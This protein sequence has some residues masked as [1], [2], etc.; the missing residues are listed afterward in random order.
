MSFKIKTLTA[1]II[2]LSLGSVLSAQELVLQAA[3]DFPVLTVEGFV[4][5][6]KKEKS[7]VLSVNAGK[8]KGK[9]AAV[10]GTFNGKTGKYNITIN[11]MK[12]FDGESTYRVKIDGKLIG[13]YQNPRTDKDGDFKPAGTTF[14]KVKVKKGATIQVE[15]NSHTNG[16][17]PEHNSTAYA[18]GRWSSLEFYLVK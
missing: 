18:R 10:Q 7:K 6:V 9:F 17:I 1:L 4:P 13:E 2:A 14:K 12:E 3:K 15:F 8:Y 5:A 11:T 16:L